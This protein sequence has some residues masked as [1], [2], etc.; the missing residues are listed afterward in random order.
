[1]FVCKRCG[2]DKDDA[3]AYP[4]PT[5]KVPLYCRTCDKRTTQRRMIVRRIKAGTFAAYLADLRAR[6]EE[7]ETIHARHAA[8]LHPV[9]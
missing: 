9:N 4:H 3:D 2:E 7:A 1:M 6:V 5:R 8:G